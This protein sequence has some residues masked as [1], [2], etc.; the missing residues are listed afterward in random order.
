MSW[1]DNHIR[2]PGFLVILAIALL[3][4]GYVMGQTPAAS[5]SMAEADQSPA[6][7]SRSVIAQW[8]IEAMENAPE[9]LTARAAL[10]SAEADVD[11]ARYAAYPQLALG[12]SGSNGQSP[13][14]GNPADSVDSRVSASLTYTVWDFGR[15]RSKKEAAALGRE[16]ALLRLEQS[17]EQFLRRL[18]VAYIEVSRFELLEEVGQS[19]R[20]ALEE[21]ERLE[22]RRVHLGGA[23]IT[24]G[25]LASSRLALSMNKVLQFEQSLQDARLRLEA[26]MGKPLQMPDLP[27]LQVPSSWTAQVPVDFDPVDAS[28]TLKAQR[29]NVDQ[30]R[31]DLDADQGG[32]YPAVA[33]TYTKRYE[34]PGSYSAR[35]T[36]G[37]QVSVDS[38][39]ALEATARVDRSASRLETEV[40]KLAM[41]EREARQGIR[42]GVQRQKLL[43]QR[44]RLLSSA[45]GDSV[46]VVDARRKLNEAG[47]ETT[48][49]LLDAQ[50]EANNTFIDWV[51][52]IYDTRVGEVELA[53]DTG[54]LAPQEGQALGMLQALFNGE[55]YRAEV[56]R[57]LAAMNR[58]P[59]AGGGHRVAPT[60]L[61]Q[62]P[63]FRLGL[64]VSQEQVLA[65][66]RR[67]GA[68]ESQFFRLEVKPFEVSGGSW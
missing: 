59:V 6:T 38:S 18:L 27:L 44:V 61:A 49:A 28:A 17:R 22:A 36:V 50:V 63:S 40:Q 42:S 12:I 14:S 21:L 31:A 1:V 15:T 11:S 3:P 24:D 35:S 25:T 58:S 67:P 20:A 48:L 41:L 19:T 29:L 32:V 53:S 45:A 10:R 43:G 46:K 54:R 37:V 52:A 8:M 55:D 33:L 30:V 62:L 23:G 34:M 16:S 66:A 64:T 5:H 57:R 4:S 2:G 56:R 9:V 51:Q 60:A 68:R 47:R 13:S 65:I 39:T 26:L 7:A